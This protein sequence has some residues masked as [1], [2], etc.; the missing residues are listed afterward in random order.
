MICMK[1][2]SVQYLT[3]PSYCYMTITY[4]KCYCEILLSNPHIFFSCCII[5]LITT[6][7]ILFVRD[8]I[9]NGKCVRIIS[10]ECYDLHTHSSF[11]Q[12]KIKKKWKLFC[13]DY[14]NKRVLT[15]NNIRLK[16]YGYK[17]TCMALGNGN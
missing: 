6:I 14:T 12:F 5:F 11:N 7:Y 9:T 2:L 16:F 1:S 15:H 17:E 10:S 4:H 3:N 13:T 8:A